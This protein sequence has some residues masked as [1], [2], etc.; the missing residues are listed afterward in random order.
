MAHYFIDS[1]MGPKMFWFYLIR[2]HLN[3]LNYGIYCFMETRITE[4]TNDCEAFAKLHLADLKRFK[5]F[6]NFI[7]LITWFF[8]FFFYNILFHDRPI[9]LFLNYVWPYHFTGPI[10]II[11]MKHLFCIFCVNLRQR[12]VFYI[13]NRLFIRNTDNDYKKIEEILVQSQELTERINT[14]YGIFPLIC[15]M[16]LTMNLTILMNGFLHL[17]YKL[18][19]FL[20]SNWLE[21]VIYLSLLMI[22]MTTLIM[23]FESKRQKMKQLL[24]Y[25]ELNPP[26]KS[27]ECEI[28]ERLLIRMHGCNDDFKHKIAFYFNN[29]I[30]FLLGNFMLFGGIFSE[31][32]VKQ[33]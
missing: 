30:V 14:V 31:I 12:S 28:K 3:F 1:E 24:T 32:I 16:I 25:I 2:N 19:L 7:F 23:N 20:F 13:E 33:L 18:E 21:P 5:K 8:V 27:D 11:N 29:D 22:F 26:R 17:K 4:L 15:Y 9:D 10:M 6:L